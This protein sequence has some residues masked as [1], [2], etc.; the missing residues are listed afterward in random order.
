VRNNFGL[1]SLVVGITCLVIGD[2]MPIVSFIGGF[3]A[4]ILGF[5]ARSQVRKGRRDKGG[6]AAAG[7]T[8]GALASFT[9][10]LTLFPFGLGMVLAIVPL[11]VVL[12]L[13]GGWLSPSHDSNGGV[14]IGSVYHGPMK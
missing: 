11:V 7:I 5:V 9:L 13:L 4:I 2:S 6:G 10:C 12:R 14:V 1:A 8:L 3:L